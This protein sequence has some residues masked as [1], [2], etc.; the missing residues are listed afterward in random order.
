MSKK[1]R[2]VTDTPPEVPTAPQ[3]PQRGGSFVK[4]ATGAL[5]Q[6]AKT[7]QAVVGKPAQETVLNDPSKD[8]ENDT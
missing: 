3:T 4:D 5:T 1:R 7:E 6:V 2:V 8:V